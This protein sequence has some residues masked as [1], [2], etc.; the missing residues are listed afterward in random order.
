MFHSYPLMEKEFD[1]KPDNLAKQEI[2]WYILNCKCDDYDLFVQ[3]CDCPA[4]DY[5][6][7][8]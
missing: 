3:L 1:F 8:N 7:K 6:V 2:K 5:D 4:V